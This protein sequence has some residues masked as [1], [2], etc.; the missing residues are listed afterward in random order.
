MERER[1]LLIISL[2]S[3]SKLKTSSAGDFVLGDIGVRRQPGCAWIHLDPSYSIA[4]SNLP[5]AIVVVGCQR[6][7]AN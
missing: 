6:S 1:Q 5:V 7:P 2:I 3:A 4:S